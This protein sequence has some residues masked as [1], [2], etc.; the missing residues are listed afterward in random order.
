MIVF[1]EKLQQSF[2]GK[3]SETNWMDLDCLVNEIRNEILIDSQKS[4]IFINDD[5]CCDVF[6]KIV[7]LKTK[8]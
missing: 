3:E 8:T 7:L 1:S 4:H 2:A 6:S 5:I